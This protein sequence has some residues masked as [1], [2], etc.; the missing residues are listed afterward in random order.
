MSRWVCTCRVAPIVDDGAPIQP[1]L[2]TQPVKAA[3]AL[4]VGRPVR[5]SNLDKQWLYF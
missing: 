5:N 3:W 1:L 2:T 4:P